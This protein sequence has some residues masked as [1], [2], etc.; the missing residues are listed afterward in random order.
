MDEKWIRE[1][2]ANH[3]GLRFEDVGVIKSDTLILISTDVDL[4]ATLDVDKAIDDIVVQ[5]KG[6]GHTSIPCIRFLW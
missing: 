4:P 6:M 5:Y 3:T 2:V 1:I